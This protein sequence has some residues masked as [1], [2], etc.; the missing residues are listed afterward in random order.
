MHSIMAQQT[1]SVQCNNLPPQVVSNIYDSG[2]YSTEICSY[3]VQKLLASGVVKHLAEH[4]FNRLPM[5]VFVEKDVKHMDVCDMGITISLQFGD[6]CS[7]HMAE[8]Q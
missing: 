2:P 3:T 4:Y 7:Y 6:N 8:N 5:Y 1:L